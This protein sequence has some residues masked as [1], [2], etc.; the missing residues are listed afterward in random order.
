MNSEQEELWFRLGAKLIG[1][2]NQ[3]ED[4]I[5]EA[6]RLADLTPEVV[7]E[8]IDTAIRFPEKMG[9]LDLLI[10]DKILEVV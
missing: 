5:M 2:I 7:V 9:I 8:F 10:A 6:A 3:F 4:G 1:K